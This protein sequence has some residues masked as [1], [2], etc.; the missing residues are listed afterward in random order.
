MTTWLDKVKAQLKAETEDIVHTVVEAN[1]DKT[2]R[3][4]EVYE[5]HIK[6]LASDSKKYAGTDAWNSAQN[7]LSEAEKISEE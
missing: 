6:W 3:I 1:L 4:I 5:K 2:I 7:A